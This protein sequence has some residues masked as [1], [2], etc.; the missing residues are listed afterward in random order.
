MLFHCQTHMTGKAKGIVLKIIPKA[1]TFSVQ[2]VSVGILVTEVLTRAGHKCFNTG[3]ESVPD[4]RYRY[5]NSVTQ[6]IKLL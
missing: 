4:F 3:T 1:N 2:S 5:Q 6:K